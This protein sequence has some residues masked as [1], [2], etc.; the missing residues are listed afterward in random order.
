MRWFNERISHTNGRKF[1]LLLT[2][3][4]CKKIERKKNTRVTSDKKKM[5]LC[6]TRAILAQVVS[7]RREPFFVAS[8]LESEK[9]R[10]ASFFYI[11][12]IFE[13]VCPRKL[14]AP[15]KTTRATPPLIRP[16]HLFSF[17]LPFKKKHMD[18][19]SPAAFY[20]FQIV[21]GARCW[22]LMGLSDRWSLSRYVN[23]SYDADR[24]KLFIE[25]R[26]K[27]EKEWDRPR[28]VVPS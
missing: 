14:A 7:H 21:I 1:L 12:F 18:V 4:S 22:D 2:R 16:S 24:R 6:E 25:G 10:S 23:L 15:E 9:M 13:D 3:G 27:E 28:R 26:R 19:F 20:Y 5:A 17:F 8:F 11:Y